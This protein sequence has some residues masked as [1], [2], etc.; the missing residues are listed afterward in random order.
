MS[1]PFFIFIV[2]LYLCTECLGITYILFKPLTE[3][4]CTYHLLILSPDKYASLVFAGTTFFENLEVKWKLMYNH[5]CPSQKLYCRTC[6]KPR[7]NLVPG[8][9][10]EGIWRPGWKGL[11]KKGE[12]GKRPVKGGLAWNCKTMAQTGTS[13]WQKDL[14]LGCI[15]TVSHCCNHSIWN[16]VIAGLHNNWLTQVSKL[17]WPPSFPGCYSEIFSSRK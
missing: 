8:S 12:N 11:A 15:L 16:K 9:G 4:W 17:K 13:G 14:Q 3:K 1:K 5:Q 10:C 7:R 2:S 6:S